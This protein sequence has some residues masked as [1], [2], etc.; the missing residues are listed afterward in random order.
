MNLGPVPGCDARGDEF[1]DSVVV[2]A[3]NKLCTARWASEYLL[4]EGSDPTGRIPP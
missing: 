1:F 3:H 2:P 4:D